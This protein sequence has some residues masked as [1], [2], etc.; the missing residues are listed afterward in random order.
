MVGVIILL[1]IIVGVPTYIFISGGF[2]TFTVVA[3]TS[4]VMVSLGV[5]AYRGGEKKS[6]AIVCTLGIIIAIIFLR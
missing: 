4:W 2:S 6:G 1:L 5:L 3:V